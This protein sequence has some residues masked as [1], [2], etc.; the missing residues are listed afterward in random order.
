MREIDTTHLTVML[1]GGTAVTSDVLS[2]LKF[3]KPVELVMFCTG[4]P[5]LES[6]LRIQAYAKCIVSAEI[7]KQ[8]IDDPFSVDMHARQGTRHLELAVM[9]AGSRRWNM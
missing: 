7:T 5:E 3:Q 1:R 4:S 6:M 8:Q 9:Y 2:A